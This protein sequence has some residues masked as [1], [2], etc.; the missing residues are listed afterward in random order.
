M[1]VGL[2][3]CGQVGGKRVRALGEHRL[4]AV[5]DADPE[6]AERLAGE[7]PCCRVAP[8]VEALLERSEIDLILVAASHD[9]LA[10]LTHRA[11]AAGKH[12]LVEKPAARRASELRPVIAA[13]RAAG[14]L[15]K[16]G[17]NHRFHPALRKARQL[18]ASDAIGP[19]LYLRARYGHG[20]RIGYEHEWRADP[21]RAGG[22][23][24]IDQGVHLIDL[25]RWYAGQLEL[26]GGA[27]GTFFWPMAVEDNA[28]LHL[29]T[30]GGIVAWLHASWT[31]W[32]NLFSFE[33]FGRDGKLEVSGLGGSYGRERLTL[34]RMGRELGPPACTV[35]EFPDEDRSWHDEL[36]H[37][38]AC[39]DGSQPLDGDL[40][41]ALA[42]LELVEQVYAFRGPVRFVPTAGGGVA[43]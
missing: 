2:I 25:A 19:L 9:A 37:F 13:A 15:V 20:G 35:W 16:V 18:L 6:R 38:E 8:D 32:K 4:V 27:V 41:D 36:A 26:A 24:L 33:L 3:G 34:Y 17:F 11:V 31:E 1:R 21:D 10:G 7:H 40:E 23:E 43:S 29:R 28:F 30:P 39:L 14:R 22:G 5:T 42:A 12:V